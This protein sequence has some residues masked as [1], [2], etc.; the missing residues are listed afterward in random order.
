MLVTFAGLMR[1]TFRESD[2]FARIGGDEFVVLL[3]NTRKAEAAEIV[4][5]FRGLVDMFNTEMD[6][7]YDIAFS[8]GIVSVQPDDDSSIDD[9]L[10]E[11][12]VLMYEKKLDLAPKMT[13]VKQ[14]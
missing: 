13:L 14:A 1:K 5:R 7:G 10:R 8:D 11:A 12:D 3:T 2:V 4:A 9:L 6:R